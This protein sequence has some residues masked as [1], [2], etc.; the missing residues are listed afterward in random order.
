MT[1]ETQVIH[2]NVPEFD[3]INLCRYAKSSFLSKENPVILHSEQHFL[4]YA[5]ERYV[6][7]AYYIPLNNQKG[8]LLEKEHIEHIDVLEKVIFEV[9]VSTLH[10]ALNN[11]LVGY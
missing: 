6:R 4:E 1:G 7:Y 10:D 5:Q 11:V 3:R 8:I 9:L 2:S